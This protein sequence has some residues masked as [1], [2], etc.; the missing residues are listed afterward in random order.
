MRRPLLL[1]V[2]LLAA[3]AAPA[4][5][6][7]APVVTADLVDAGATRGVR[8]VRLAVTGSCG[9]GAPAG[10]TAVVEGRLRRAPRSRRG[11]SGPAFAPGVEELGTHG[12]VAGTRAVFRFRITGGWSAVGVAE[13]ECQAPDGFDRAR[14]APTAPILAPVRLEGWEPHT[15]SWEGKPL[16]RCDPPRSRRLQAGADYLLAFDLGPIDARTLF[17]HP[18]ATV[19]RR[20]LAPVRYHITGGGG[21]PPPPPPPAAHLQRVGR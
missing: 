16:A 1:A 8:T 5:A 13:I 17:R 10:T 2:L 12:K 3:G 14:S 9:A 7:L 4:R 18:G 21:P 11:A 20:D 6:E 19:R 15:T